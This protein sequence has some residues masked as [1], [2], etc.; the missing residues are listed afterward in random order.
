M[1][2]MQCTHVCVFDLLGIFLKNVRI[3]SAFSAKISEDIKCHSKFCCMFKLLVLFHYC[4]EVS[5]KE[6]FNIK[7]QY[8]N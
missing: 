6:Y 3:G 5:V 4:F 2:H 7:I 8:K 1:L